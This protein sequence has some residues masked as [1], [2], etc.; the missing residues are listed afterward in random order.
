M[1]LS[2]I[3]FV[4]AQIVGVLSLLICL[5]VLAIV[6]LLAAAGISGE[7]LWLQAASKPGTLLG[8]LIIGVLLLGLV[9]I[10]PFVGWAI[11]LGLILAGLGGSIIALFSRRQ[12]QPETETR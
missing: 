4:L 2:A 11:V 5:P 12:A 10:V 6:G 9:L 3:E 1:L 7:K 8:S